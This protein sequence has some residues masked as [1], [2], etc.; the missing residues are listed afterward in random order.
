M[1]LAWFLAVRFLRE[2]RTQTLLL[3]AGAST[4]VLLVVFLSAL[5]DGLQRDLIAKTLGSQAHL[6]IKQPDELP[7]PIRGPSRPGELVAPRIERPAQRQRTWSNWEPLVERVRVEP[8][9]R[10]AAPLVTGPALATRGGTSSAVALFGVQPSDFL[11]VYDV[12]RRL[13]KGVFDTA[14]DHVL[15]GR[16]LADELGVG[17]G[18]KLRLAGAAQRDELFT[19]AGVFDMGVRDVNRR[20]VIL[21]LR[22][23]QSLLELQG[24]ISQ[25]DLRLVDPFAAPAVA[26]TLAAQTGLLVESWTATNTQLLAGLKAQEGSSQLIQTFVILGVA[27]AIASVLVISVVQKQRQIGILRA[28]GTPRPM[29]LRIFLI[30]GGL[31][32]LAGSILGSLLGAW[33]VY[34]FSTKSSVQFPITLDARLFLRAASLALGTGLLAAVMPARRAARL[35]P[36]VAIRH[37]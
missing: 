37:E 34:L 18:D 28:M 1:R 29:V 22:S 6:V 4:G 23:A 9:V 7:T 14:A 8:G 32:G 24:G 36:A 33:M 27:V 11:S 30:Q 3:I 25:I 15:I 20:W 2:G 31:I 10:A 12:D 13:I 21:S 19:I 5:I 26:A 35:E 16:E 17:V